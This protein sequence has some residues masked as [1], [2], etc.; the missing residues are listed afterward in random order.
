MPRRK[1]DWRPNVYSHVVM[2]GNNRANVYKDD[3][4]KYHL[5]RCIGEAHQQYRF[6]IAAFCI[7]SNHFHLLIQSEDDLSLIM[8]RINRRY[9]DYYAK[10]YRHV[11][12]IYQCRYFAKAI[13]DP[14]VLLIV[15]RYIHRNPIETKQPMVKELQ[16][17]PHSSFPSYSASSQTAA[18]Y[19]DFTRLPALLSSKYPRDCA[20]YCRYCLDE[21]DEKEMM[22]DQQAMSEHESV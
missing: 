22:A 12:R 19:M 7:M 17:Y 2:R 16:L 8:A 5:M 20:G 4:D 13:D 6:M 14:Q 10:R 18:P 1:R 9:S 3:Q 11:G 21:I 15:S